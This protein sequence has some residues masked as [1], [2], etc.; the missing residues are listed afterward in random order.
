LIADE[1]EKR[2]SCVKR[3][4][5]PI[6]LTEEPNVERGELDDKPADWPT[7][8]REMLVCKT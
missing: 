8:H 1:E 6:R 3:I 5:L 4:S 7:T 2:P